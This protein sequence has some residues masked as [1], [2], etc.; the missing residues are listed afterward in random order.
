M[1]QPRTVVD[2]VCANPCSE[3]ALQNVILLIRAFRRGEDRERVGPVAVAQPR[4]LL[5]YDLH[6]L[7]PRSFAEGL[8]PIRRG[9][10]AIAR[11]AKGAIDRWEP[12]QRV[13][14]RTRLVRVGLP[15][16]VAPRT[17]A[18]APPLPMPRVS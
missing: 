15:L 9:G 3:E 17:S 12:S 8:V 10:D 11:I 2:V 5:R 13:H 1:A 6:R 4:E 18:A 7:V 14:P 16:D